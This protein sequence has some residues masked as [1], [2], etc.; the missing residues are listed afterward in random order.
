[1][2][3]SLLVVEVRYSENELCGLTLE[4]TGPLRRVGIWARLL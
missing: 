3:L 1:M 4:L 2:G